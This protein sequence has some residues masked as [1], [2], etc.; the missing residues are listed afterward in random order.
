L[1]GGR[2]HVRHPPVRAHRRARLHRR[3]VA[4][5]PGRGALRARGGEPAEAVRPQLR[6]ARRRGVSPEVR[7]ALRR[8]TGS[9]SSR[10][11]ISRRGS[12]APRARSSRFRRCATC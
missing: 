10:R 6:R 5:H 7:G 3:R 8:P 11:S 12:R 4:R 9:S 2:R 1:G